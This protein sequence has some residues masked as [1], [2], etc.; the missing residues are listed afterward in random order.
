MRKLFTILAIWGLSVGFTALTA[1][2]D[3]TVDYTVNGTFGS[4]TGVPSTSISNAG[5]SF[6]ITFSVDQALLVPTSFNSG[7]T[8]A[9]PIIFDYTDFLGSTIKFSLPNQAGMITFFNQSNSGLFQLEF[10]PP[11]SGHDFFLD[12]IGSNPNP[13]LEN[14][15]GSPSNT[16]QFSITSGNAMGDASFLAEGGTA[17]NFVFSRPDQISTATAVSAPEPSSLLLL[18]SGFLALG[19][20]VRRRLIARFN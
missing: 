15:L 8:A 11:P 10:F 12:L 16:G 20:L 2:A 18:G 9:I 7:M 13:T 4:L 19:G 5:D 1:S 6:T 17:A 3:T 14:F